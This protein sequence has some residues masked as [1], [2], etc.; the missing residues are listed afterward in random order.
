MG[1][2]TS[3]FWRD[4]ECK[5]TLTPNSM[6]IIPKDK[7][8]NF[9]REVRKHGDSKPKQLSIKQREQLEG[10]RFDSYYEKFNHS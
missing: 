7:F 8:I 5:N 6:G 10:Y 2:V 1:A 9:A 4:K 3:M